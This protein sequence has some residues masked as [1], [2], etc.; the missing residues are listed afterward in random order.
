M[1]FRATILILFSAFLPSCQGKRAPAAPSAPPR[2]ERET[3][4]EMFARS[5]VPGRSGQIYVVAEK[6]NF[7]LARPDDVYRFMHGSPWEYDTEIPILFH[8]EPFIRRGVYSGPA[9]QQDVAPTL[10][11][12]LGLPAPTTM[13]GR[14]LRE[15]ISPGSERPRVILLLVLDGLGRDTYERLAPQLPTLRR[16]RQ[17]GAWFE[18]AR[19][20]YLPTVTSAGHSTVSTGVDPRFHGIH[21]NATFDRRTNKEDEPF[22]GLSPKNYMTLALAD[23]WSLATSG[24]AIVI[25][26]G[27]TSRAAVALAGLG[28]CAINGRPAVMAM[29]DERKAG[30]VTNKECF[31]L[32][33]YLE[34]DNAAKVW[35]AAGGTWLDHK[36]DSGRTILRTGLFPR[37]Q[38][39]AL[40]EMIEKESV[41]KD[42][43][44]DLVLANFKTPDYVAHQYGPSSKEMEEAMRALDPELARVLSALDGAAGAGRTVLALTAD[45]GMPDEPRVPK[46]DRRYVED[47][48]AAVHQRFD[49]EGKLVIDF[50]DAANCQMY[51]SLERLE[52]LHLRLGDVAAFL[53]EMPF[54]RYAFTEDQV[55]STRVR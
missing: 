26:Q 33:A 35:E 49:P 24:R 12:I 19:I 15:A 46:E 55:R 42:E 9:R 6:G 10:A 50:D 1:V 4:L 52:E 34:D 28:A 8:G 29:F 2:S 7:F 36:I 53:E 22:P 13:N 47:I 30:W 39:D 48:E 18:N 5:Y 23:H 51:V 11:A 21:A 31:R 20:D 37:F 14:V 43:I 45:H 44:P 27:T 3:V 54:I 16:I 40:I 41:G 32:P 25:A 38:A 17:E